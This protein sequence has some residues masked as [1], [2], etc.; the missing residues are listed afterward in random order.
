MAMRWTDA[1]RRAID[2]RGNLIVSAAAGAG[3][4]AVLTERI[5]SLVAGGVSVDELLVLTFTRAAAAEMKLRIEQRLQRAVEETEDETLR[6]RFVAEAGNVGSAHIS[7]ID[8]FCTR[9][10]RRHGHTIGLASGVRVADEVEL[11]VLSE[12]LRDELLTKLSAAEDADYLALLR[13]FRSEDTVWESVCRLSDFLDAQADPNGWLEQTAA[14]ADSE[15]YLHAVLAEILREQ[16]LALAA[17]VEELQRCR[18]S[19]PPSYD[20][21]IA[22]LDEDLSRCRALLLQ[23]K[24]DAYRAGLIT[25]S[26]STMRFP[27]GTEEADKK[28]AQDTRDHLKKQIKKQMAVFARSAAEEQEILQ[29]G[30]AVLRAL[31]AVTRAYRDAL[32]ELK[33]R[34]GVIDFVD[35]EHFALQLLSDDNIA[36]E[37]RE[38]FAY[39]AV[40]EYQDSNGVQEALLDRIKRGDNLFLVGDVKQSIYRFR[41]AEPALFLEKLVR[42][43]GAEGS[44]IDL[45]ENFRSAPEVLSAVNAVFDTVMSE[46]VGELAYDARARL[47]AGGSVPHGGAVLHLVPKTFD[48][49]IP[50][51]TGWDTDPAAAEA[52]GSETEA[53]DEEPTQATS[54][55]QDM[56]DDPEDAADAAVEARLI[57]RRIRELIDTVPC[58]DAK[59]GKER[60]LT[61]GDFAILLRTGGQAQLVA[62]TLALSGIP[63]YAQASGGYF[64]AVEVMVLLN[65]LRVVD[66]RLQDIPLLSVLR[67]PLFDFTAEDLAKIRLLERK[68]PFHELFFSV[69]ASDTAE[70]DLGAELFEKV[71]HTVGTIDAYR[72]ESTLVGMAELLTQIVDETGYYDIM[73][74]LPA[75][76]QRQRNIDALIDR[77]RSFESTGARGVWR[78]LRTMDAAKSN[79]RIG[80]AQE[81]AGD[82]VRIMTIHKS[83][84]LEYPVVFVAQMGKKFRF[85]DAK[86]PVLL[87]GRLGAGMRFYA[88]GVRYDTASRRGIA[89]V[90]RM[91]QLSEEMRVLYVAMTRAKQRLEL[92]ASVRNPETEIERAKMPAT[93]ASAA[94][95]VSFLPWLLAGANAHRGALPL[96]IHAR[97]DLLAPAVK[98]QEPTLT[99]EK[100]PEL[101]ALEARFAFRYPFAE[102]TALPA[103]RGV[104][105]AARDR[106]EAGEQ[107]AE[108]LRFDPPNFLSADSRE[109]TAAERGTTVHRL[110]ERLP[111]RAMSAEEAETAV[112]SLAEGE[113]AAGRSID[114]RRI[115]DLVWLLSSPLYARMANSPRIQREWSFARTVSAGTVFETDAEEAV[116]LQGVIDCCFIEDGAWVLVD[117]KTDRLRAGEK[118]EIHA[119]QHEAQLAIYAEALETLTGIP[120][121]ERIVVLLTPH[122]AVSV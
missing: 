80:A 42:W 97:A 111:I 90:Q 24:Y 118:P 8:A 105:T 20:K 78:F 1:Q 44:R 98:A 9:I 84:G 47:Y 82:V 34:R 115:A 83:K 87:H 112:L 33:R 69:P 89:A 60:S 113:R 55:S 85:D 96:R 14:A 73:G 109:Q 35:V 13:A 102:A 117:Y 32:A 48:A 30:A 38:K 4:T 67:S 23:E 100:L 43:N 92:I 101:A 94:R 88:D 72:M 86:I 74:A 15:D 119:K 93:P 21:V 114:A 52:D 64:D 3:K 6:A 36:A 49:D 120:V 7:T 17:S 54:V 22:V 28:P 108:Q 59:L 45:N 50:F 10:L 46:R 53:R 25:M 77:A 99:E 68:R 91:E 62:E 5:C 58:Y 121:K 57:A 61:Y 31:A 37:Y 110:L 29:R 71:C 106:L 65:L 79:A 27:K 116:L 16:Q 122:A 2:E 56:E 66:N 76:Q 11:A 95:A 18:D 63:A 104:T 41:A 103:K 19:L 39:I 75:G 26:F 12:R 107:D 40:D 51:A 81:A 70:A